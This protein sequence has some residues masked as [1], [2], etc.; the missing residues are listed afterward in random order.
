MADQAIVATEQERAALLDT[1]PT[2]VVEVLPVMT[3]PRLQP[4]GL[5]ERN[6]VLF[7]VEAWCA[8]DRNALLW[9]VDAAWPLVRQAVPDAVLRIAGAGA[10]NDVLALGVQPGVEV[11]GWTG[12]VLALFDQHRVLVAPQRVGVGGPEI[13][14][15]GLASG[16]PA[17]M[18]SL[19]A[20]MLRLQDGV[21]VLAADG[22][23]EFAMHVAD[24]LRDD[25]LWSRLSDR[26]RAYIAHAYP[27]SLFRC[28]MDR[29]FDG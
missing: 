25:A 3:R 2:A 18:A 17:V 13:A 24:L 29:F 8:E 14:A 23:R 19:A 7:M 16:L 28:R 6:G 5:A 21:T 9:F 1:A 12:N 27:A 4:P 22:G 26:G 20:A 10:D 15:A 11:V